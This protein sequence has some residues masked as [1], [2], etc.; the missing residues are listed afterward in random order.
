MEKPVA[1]VDVPASVHLVRWG[2]PLPAG[3]KAQ[4]CPWCGGDKLMGVLIGPTADE[5]DPDI[6]C[7]TCD[8]AW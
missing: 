3:Y 5:V 8:F 1:L 2:T 4:A 6:I 7:L